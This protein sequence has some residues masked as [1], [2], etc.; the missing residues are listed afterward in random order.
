[1]EQPSGMIEA[2]AAYYEHIGPLPP[3]STLERYDEALPGLAERVVGR[4]EQESDHR[5]TLDKR[6]QLIAAILG[7][8]GLIGGLG[9]IFTNHDWAGVAV[10][11]SGVAPLV[12]AFVKGPHQNS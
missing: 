1:M 3:P 12:F 6:G 5:H 8:G 10:I 2:R 4:M 9:A 11:A 7:A